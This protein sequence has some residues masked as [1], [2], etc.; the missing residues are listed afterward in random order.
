MNLWAFL[1]KDLLQ[2]SIRNFV[3]WASVVIYGYLPGKWYEFLLAFGAHLLWTGFLGILF[4]YLLP[5]LTMQG[6]RVKGALFGFI[7]GFFIYGV[8]ILLRMPFFTKIPFL[9]STS[10]AIGGIL[11]GFTT[12]HALGWLDRVT[13]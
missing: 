5:K 13:K 10:N 11:W 8:A 2:I 7:I 4:S 9:T 1:A 3:D 6:F 12:A